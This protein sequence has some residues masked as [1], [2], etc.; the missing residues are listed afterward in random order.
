MWTLFVAFG[1]LIAATA[2]V[3][4]AVAVVIG[5]SS[6]IVPEQHRPATP[7]HQPVDGTVV[8][9]GVADLRLLDLQSGELEPVRVPGS[10]LVGSAA[11]SPWQDSRGRVHLVGL[12]RSRDA[13]GYSAG[14]GLARY[15][16]PGVEELD[17]VE[18]EVPPRGPVCWFPGTEA[19]V[20]FIGLDFRIYSF[21]FDERGD[22][23]G[24]KELIWRM[25]PPV[26]GRPMVANLTWP[27]DP[28]LGGR[29]FV[30]LNI[31]ERDESLWWLELDP[32]GTAIERSGRL[33]LTA[34]GGGS[35]PVSRE[36][37]AGISAAPDGGLV[38]AYFA[39]RRG[40][41][42]Y[43]LRIGPVVIDAET[44][45]P[46]VEESDTVVVAEDR[47]AHPPAFSP[48]GRWVYSI[49]RAGRMPGRA[50][51]HSVVDV[52]A[53]RRAP[54]WRPPVVLQ[55][56]PPATRIGRRVPSRVTANR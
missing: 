5:R 11:C 12:W 3:V 23:T 26:N 27:S 10:D 6:P 24:P 21:S 43:Q 46:R 37:F 19:R 25:R 13:N 35:E 14:S 17:R 4:F 41:A 18:L 45:A 8:L 51:R 53:R 30:S 20:L 2:V 38:A 40:H 44:G 33:I 47:A 7:R 16:L 42:E 29:A 50:E 31:G 49:P 48:D 22:A 15:A 52:L 1:R 9:K 55:S 32:D 28:R 34:P 54:S 36:L 39:T 56:P